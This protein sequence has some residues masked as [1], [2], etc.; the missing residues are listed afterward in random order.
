MTLNE[1]AY[2]ILD[3]IQKDP[4]EQWLER[5]RYSIKY[6]RALFIRRDLAKNLSYSRHFVQV[7]KGLETEKSKITFGD[8]PAERIYMK[9]LKRIPNTIRLK[10]GVPLVRVSDVTEDYPIQHLTIGQ[11]RFHFASKYTGKRPR[12]IIYEDHIYLVSS[13]S[14]LIN[15][16]GIFEDPIEAML[17]NGCE[18]N[19]DPNDLEF[20][21]PSDLIKSIT[22][23][24]VQ[25][26][27]LPIQQLDNEIRLDGEKA[28]P[29][30]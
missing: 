9:T 21:I 18:P 22:D 30:G 24:I 28:A 5:I 26:E 20:P 6:H 4:D 12:Y 10:D 23:T 17:L 19:V 25:S 15:I 1:I 29:N 16:H 13:F 7:I 8:V 11:M 3:L 2:N 14:K 27:L